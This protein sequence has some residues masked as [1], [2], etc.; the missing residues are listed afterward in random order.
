MENYQRRKQARAL[1]KHGRHG[2]RYSSCIQATFKL[3]IFSALKR[4]KVKL[5]FE[6]KLKILTKHKLSRFQVNLFG[7]IRLKIETNLKIVW[8][9]AVNST[10][11]LPRQIAGN[12][13]HSRLSVV[14]LQCGKESVD[15]ESKGIDGE[16]STES[17]K[18][19]ALAEWLQP[20]SN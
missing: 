7:D 15:G 14:I 20:Q 18:R 9:L 17:V 19:R 11:G 12:L 16:Y 2:K 5:T 10:E 4:C 1:C 13:L 6:V 8:T 3:W